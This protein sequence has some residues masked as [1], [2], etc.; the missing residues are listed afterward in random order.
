MLAKEM[1]KGSEARVEIDRSLHQLGTDKVKVRRNNFVP[2]WEYTTRRHSLARFTLS[3]IMCNCYKDKC[4][5]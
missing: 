1:A 5:P 4:V 2:F 3:H